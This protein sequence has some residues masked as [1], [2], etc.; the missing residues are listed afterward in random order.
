MDLRDLG[1]S[2]LGRPSGPGMSRAS[3]IIALYGA[4]AAVAVLI[5]VLRGGR[6]STA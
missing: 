3:L 6:I 4:L 5:G 1:S 2:T